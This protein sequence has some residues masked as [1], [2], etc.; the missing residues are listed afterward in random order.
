M[1][2]LGCNMKRLVINSSYALVEESTASFFAEPDSQLAK[3][4]APAN[5]KLIEGMT[6]GSPKNEKL[7]TSAAQL[8]GAYAFGFLEDCCLDE[9]AQEAA[10]ERARALYL[11]SRDYAIAALNLDYDFK[12]MLKLE[13]AAFEKA[14]EKIDVEGVPPLFWATF[15][16]GLYI[17]LTRSDLEALADLSRVAAMARRVQTL[18]P[19]YFYGGADMFLM[20]FAS[21]MG[22]AVGGS[23]EQ[24]KQAYERAIKQSDGKFLL[25]KYLFAKYYGQQTMDRALFEKTLQEILDAP[26]N[27]LPEQNLSNQLAKEKAARLLAQAEDLF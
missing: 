19:S 15:S 21:A 6:Q 1:G 4:A 5:L 9:D 17:N 23:P 10:N 11:R 25:T 27:A 3:E 12:T 14:L 18:D 26:L 7:L 13:Q 22:P 2:L 20:V 16:W 8:L 24:A